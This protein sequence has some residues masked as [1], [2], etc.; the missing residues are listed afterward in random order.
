MMVL[1]IHNFHCNQHLNR[2]DFGIDPNFYN[3][4]RKYDQDDN[5]SGRSGN[6]FVAWNYIWNYYYGII[7]L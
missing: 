4:I 1:F 7:T 2:F 3:Y 6:I 5:V